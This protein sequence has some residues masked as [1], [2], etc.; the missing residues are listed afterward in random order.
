MYFCIDED[1]QIS[2]GKTLQECWTNA[3]NEGLCIYGN[4]ECTILSSTVKLFKGEEISV[5]LVPEKFIPSKLTEIKN[6][7]RRKQLRMIMQLWD[8]SD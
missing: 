5:S 1:G 7:H 4:D 6:T 2:S 3:G 8:N